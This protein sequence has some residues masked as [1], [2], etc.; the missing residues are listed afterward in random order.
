MV[1]ELYFILTELSQEMKRKVRSPA[2]HRKL[3]GRASK[4]ALIQYL[5]NVAKN[6][7][8]IESFDFTFVEYL[9]DNGADINDSDIIGQSSFHIVAK[10]WSIDVARFL[11]DHGKEAFEI[12]QLE[13]IFL[14]NYSFNYS[15][16]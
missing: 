15:F 14:T 13:N 11:L 16:N 9:L 4:Y 5:S 7:S 6:R 1:N 10:F 3:S 8:A 2:T 12:L